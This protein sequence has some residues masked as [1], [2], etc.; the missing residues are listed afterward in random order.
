[1]RKRAGWIGRIESRL[2]RSPHDRK[3]MA[4]LKS[5]GREAI[6]DYTVE[7]TY[8]PE[9]RPLAARLR[10]R[11]HTGR[12]HQ[13]RVQLASKGAPCLGDAV[14][15]SGAPARPVK[16]AIESAQLSRQ[17]LHAAVLGFV[18]PITGE[19]MRFE[20]PPPADMQALEQALEAL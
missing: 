10:C 9:A 12:T 6:T 14:Y 3:K 7:R 5:G 18:H 15:G 19:T 2:G 4:V 20:T 17:A 8:G 16:D 11:L 13:I 1:M